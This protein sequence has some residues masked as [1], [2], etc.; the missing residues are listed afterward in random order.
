MQKKVGAAAKLSFAGKP[1]AETTPERWAVIGQALDEAGDDC[2][3]EYEA[4][5]TVHGLGVRV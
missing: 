2:D 5:K 1:L 4:Q 3:R